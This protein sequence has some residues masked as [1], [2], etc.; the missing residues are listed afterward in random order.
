MNWKAGSA[1]VLT[2]MLLINGSIIVSAEEIEPAG[3]HVYDVQETEATD[4]WYGIGRGTYL[5]A[6]TAKLTED[7]PGYALCS[8]NTIA[9]HA[10]DRIYVRIYLDESDNG[11]N[12]WGTIDYW[13]GETF[14][15][16]VASAG[17]GSYKVPRGKYYRVKGIHSV[18]E[19]VDGEN[20]TEATT[21]CTDALLFD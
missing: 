19:N 4:S 12:D 18:T 10:C 21:T 11:Y 6:G 9:H 5:Q 1:L 8:G 17:S 13:T 7:A 16:S 20:F 14:D 2:G 15:V 3:Y